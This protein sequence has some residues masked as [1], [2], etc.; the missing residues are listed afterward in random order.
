[1]HSVRILEV[2]ESVA[3]VCILSTH[4]HVNLML[5]LSTFKNLVHVFLSLPYLLYQLENTGEV[6]DYHDIKRVITTIND[7]NQLL[8]INYFDYDDKDRICH[9]EGM[10]VMVLVMSVVTMVMI[11]MMIS[12]RA[13]N[14]YNIYS[15]QYAV[16]IIHRVVKELPA[17]SKHGIVQ[18]CIY[19]GSWRS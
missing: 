19:G 15:M 10:V 5:I 12:G 2:K 18:L 17:G 3:Y 4:S 13:A 6:D 9:S 1:M 8:L 11:S 14:S 16:H 7:N